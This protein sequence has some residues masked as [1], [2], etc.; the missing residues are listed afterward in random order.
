MQVA[1]NFIPNSVVTVHP[2][3]KPWV[4]TDLKKMIKRSNLLWRRYQR[5]GSADH[6]RTFK[7]LL[8]RVV[9]LNWQLRN[10]YA[11]AWGES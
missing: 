10:V 3:E 9:S 1:S 5:S 6:Y 7:L 8:S 2:K 4:N 11:L